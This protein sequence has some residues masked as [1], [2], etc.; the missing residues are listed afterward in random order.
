MQFKKLIWVMAAI[1][2]TVSL[3]SCNIGKAAEPTQDVNAIYTA[4]AGT[5]L[6]QFGDQMTQTAQAVPPTSADSPTPLAT[7]TGLPTFS[8]GPGTTPFSGTPFVFNTP[9]GAGTPLPTLG[10]G[11]STGSTGSTASGCSDSSY[12]AQT[13]PDGTS[14]TAHKNFSVGFQMQNTGTCQWDQGFSFSFVSGDRMNGN[15]IV[16]TSADTITKP[17]QSNTFILKLQAPDTAGEY[18]GFWKMKD[19]KGNFFGSLVW[20]D[21]VV[22]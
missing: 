18:K 3:T 14:Y 5:M 4:A 1:I 2:L 7:F 22:K 10:T 21:I 19:D 17:G 16:Y 11:G 13:V 9:A 6:A 20:I 15:D 8:L 12:V